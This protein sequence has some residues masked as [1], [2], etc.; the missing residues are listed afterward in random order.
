MEIQLP[1]F[2]PSRY[3]NWLAL[4]LVVIRE[5]NVQGVPLNEETKVKL[6]ELGDYAEQREIMEQYGDEVVQYY[7][8][9]PITLIKAR[10]FDFI[11]PNLPTQEEVYRFSHDLMNRSEERR[12]GKE[13]R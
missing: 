2:L 1:D 11:I 13:C 7:L 8:E 6:Y 12:V 10:A 3:P 5:F 4:Y 9:F